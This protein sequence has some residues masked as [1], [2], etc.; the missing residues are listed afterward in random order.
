[1]PGWGEVA[2]SA[3]I[4]GSGDELGKLEWGIG[5]GGRRSVE[6]GW[7]PLRIRRQQRRKEGN[8]LE[9]GTE[10]NGRENW[11]GWKDG[12]DRHMNFAWQNLSEWLLPCQISSIRLRREKQLWN[13]LELDCESLLRPGF[14]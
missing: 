5:K 4:T 11:R 1:M 6:L 10:K 14:Y 7:H 3:L 12:A 2:D 13:A 9:P 8:W